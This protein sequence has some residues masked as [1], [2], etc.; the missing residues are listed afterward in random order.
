[1]T[2]VRAQSADL[3]VDRSQFPCQCLKPVELGDLFG[4]APKGRRIGKGFGDAL[5]FDFTQETK[6]QMAGAIGLRAVA[7]RLAT[8]ARNRRY[9]PGAKVTQ[10]EKLLHESTA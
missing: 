4:G 10:G 5:A 2:F 6:L 8:T 1:M 7:S 3:L 9:G